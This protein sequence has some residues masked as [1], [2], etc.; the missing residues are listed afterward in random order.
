MYTISGD[1]AI[2]G[3]NVHADYLE[4]TG[5]QQNADSLRWATLVIQSLPEHI[6]DLPTTAVYISE[7]KQQ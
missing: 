2:A 3:L 5:D 7:H 6:V 1:N 4:S